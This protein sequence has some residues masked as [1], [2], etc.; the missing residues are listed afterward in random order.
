MFTNA[1]FADYIIQLPLLAQRGLVAISRCEL[2]SAINYYYPLYCRSR[3]LVPQPLIPID[4]LTLT[5]IPD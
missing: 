2:E 3:G 5:G 4:S 1:D